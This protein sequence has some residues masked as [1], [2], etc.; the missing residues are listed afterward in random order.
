MKN[1]TLI[2]LLIPCFTLC[3]CSNILKQS[4]PSESI[5]LFYKSLKQYI[6]Y[7]NTYPDLT[8]VVTVTALIKNDTVKFE[9]AQ[10][11]SLISIFNQQVKK[12]ETINGCNIL[13]LGGFPNQIINKEDNSLNQDSLYRS[14]FPKD[15][16][17]LAKNG[18]CPSPEEINDEIQVLH[19]CVK[20]NMMISSKI[21]Y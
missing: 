17:F 12:A 4:K 20:G 6:S 16:E 11:S 3:F 15:Y 2:A 8:R 21:E 10:A 14:L 5:T 19:L 9:F 1:R 18:N 7:L 13:F